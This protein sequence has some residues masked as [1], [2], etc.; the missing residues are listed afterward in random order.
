VVGVALGLLLAGR[1]GTGEALITPGFRYAAKF[2]CGASTGDLAVDPVAKGVYATAINVHNHS[3]NMIDIKKKAV[4]APREDDPSVASGKY[5]TFTMPPDSATEMD[6]KD[7]FKL[8]GFTMPPFPDFAKGFV[9]VESGV[10]LDVVG[11][12]TAQRVETS[13]T[14]GVGH[15]V[16]VDTVEARDHPPPATTG[17][18]YPV[19]FV[20]GDPAGVVPAPVTPGQYFTAINVHNPNGAAVNIQKKF[21]LAESELAPFT[22]PTPFFAKTLAANQAFEIDCPDIRSRLQAS[23]ITVPPLFRGWVVLAADRELDVVGV[24]TTTETRVISSDGGVGISID[25]EPVSPHARPYPPEPTPT[26]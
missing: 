17:V 21:V 7:I 3:R 5:F 12:Y 25:L 19:K 15:S 16:D 8:L 10:E 4:L 23:G 22:P 6:C 2:V 9:I 26:P 14:P 13:G 24:Y 18:R 1:G 20:C 11:V